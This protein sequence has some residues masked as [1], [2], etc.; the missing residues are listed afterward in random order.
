MRE[1]REWSEAT[2]RSSKSEADKRGSSTFRGEERAQRGEGLDPLVDP[3]KYGAVREA[4]NLLVPDGEEFVLKFGVAMPVESD[5][6]TT[7]SMSGN[8]D[9]AFRVLPKVQNLLVQGT[10]AVLRRYHTQIATG[11]IQDQGDTFPYQRS[12]FEPDNEVERQMG[13][14]VPERG[15]GDAPEEYQLSLF[16]AAYLSQTDIR[17]YGLKGY[18]F[19]VGDELGRDR[20]DRRLLQ[21]VFGASVFEKAFGPNPSQ[22][23]PSIAE[24][25]K[26]ALEDWHVFFLQVGANEDTVKWWTKLLGRERVIRLPKTEDLAEVQACVIGLTEGVISIET[27]SDALSANRA[28]EAE[29]IARAVAGIPVGLQATYPNFTNIPSIGAR[30]RSRN[31]IWPMD[32]DAKTGKLKSSKKEP[33]APKTGDKKK[34]DAD[35]KL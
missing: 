6:D 33:K 27:L 21:Q 15:G 34:D 8:V 17:K 30:F 29:R 18:Y 4:R 22:S 1:K 23:L 24:V 3:A 10:R 26:K 11:V 20:L 28:S 32:A 12:Q 9:I 13:I 7:G 25:A 31:D 2:Y 5:L 35:W 19:I 16:A 14:L